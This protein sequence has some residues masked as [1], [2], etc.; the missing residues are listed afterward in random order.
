[1]E[2]AESSEEIDPSFEPNVLALAFRV[3]SKEESPTALQMT[4]AIGK[5]VH[6]LKTTRIPACFG[7]VQRYF[8][9]VTGNESCGNS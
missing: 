9:I 2:F 8:T 5:Y 4:S 6:Y 7:R 1:M 3:C